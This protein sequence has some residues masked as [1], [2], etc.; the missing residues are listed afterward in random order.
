MSCIGL[1]VPA[2]PNCCPHRSRR[3]RVCT[4]SQRQIW[5]AICS[6]CSMTSVLQQTSAP[7]NIQSPKPPACGARMPNTPP[8]RTAENHGAS[9]PD[10]RSSEM[11]RSV[12]PAPDCRSSDTSSDPQMVKGWSRRCWRTLH[13]AFHVLGFTHIFGKRPKTGTYEIYRAR[14]INV[15]CLTRSINVTEILRKFILGSKVP[16]F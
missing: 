13:Y 1:G 4:S 7:L 3:R 6:V 14:G 12:C 9:V 16:S 15:R 10:Q 2:K 5:M 11:D 8:R